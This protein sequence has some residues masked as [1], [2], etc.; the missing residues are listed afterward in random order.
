MKE[1]KVPTLIPIAY[2]KK[3]LHDPFYSR[4]SRYRKVARLMMESKFLK[5]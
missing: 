5:K 3:R 1:E 2:K 4:L